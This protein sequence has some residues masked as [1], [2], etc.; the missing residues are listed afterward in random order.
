VWGL[1]LSVD[2]GLSLFYLVV[3]ADRTVILRFPQA[4]KVNIPEGFAM[5]ES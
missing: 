3:L 4:M 5:Y 2:L 1:T